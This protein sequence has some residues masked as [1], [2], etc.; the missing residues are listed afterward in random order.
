MSK[1]NP[2]KEEILEIDASV[3]NLEDVI[4]DDDNFIGIFD[5]VDDTPDTSFQN[6]DYSFFTPS[7]DL[8]DLFLEDL[9]YENMIS[10]N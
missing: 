8:D 6:E 7:D 10:S 3:Q 9:T 4:Q 5:E 2:T 1:Q